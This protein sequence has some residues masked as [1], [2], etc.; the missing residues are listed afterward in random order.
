M[1]SKAKEKLI[2]SLNIK[3]YRD[4]Y[5][6]FYIEGEKMLDDILDSSLN[7]KTVFVT[8]ELINKYNNISDVIEVTDNELSRISSLVTHRNVLAIIEKPKNVIAKNEI[9]NSLSILLDKVQNPG[10]IGTIIRTANWFGIKNVFCSSDS[11]DIYSPKAIQATMGAISNVN[12]HYVNI[13]DFLESFSKNKKFIIS[14]S[15]LEGENI[16]KTKLTR[17]GIIIMGNEGNGISKQCEKYVN[18]KIYIPNYPLDNKLTDSLNVSI[19]T[20]IICSEYRASL[21]RN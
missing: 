4:K 15:F 13:V 1:I 2:K 3:K 17:T 12:V 9:Y 14:G 10:N 11:A 20:A 16:Y 21:L 19:A 6:Y 18:K 5:N 7:V 8:K